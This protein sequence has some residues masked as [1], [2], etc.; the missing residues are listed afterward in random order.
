VVQE[1]SSQFAELG[2]Q[3][4]FIVVEPDALAARNMIWDLSPSGP[5]VGFVDQLVDEV[6][7]RLC[8]DT[9]RVYLTGFSMGGM[10]S[11]VL[12]CRDPERY[13]AIAPVAGVIAIEGCARETPIPVIAFHGTADNAVRFDG[14]L[15]DNVAFVVPYTSGPSREEIVRTWAA[16]NGCAV[17]AEDAALPPDVDIETYDCPQNGSVEMYVVED[18]G[19]T[20]PGSTP[21]PYSAALAGRTTQTVDAT[22]LIWRFFEQH[23]RAG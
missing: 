19:H 16:K 7:A 18:G 6:E 2:R 15:A 1:R 21:G 9:S 17:P 4:D 5:D 23:S 10:M 20:W 3:R 12:A 13:A 11:M 22:D 14:S 8:V